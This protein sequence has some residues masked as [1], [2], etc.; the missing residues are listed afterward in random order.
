MTMSQAFEQGMTQ[1]QLMEEICKKLDQVLEQQK[2]RD[3][4]LEEFIKEQRQRDERQ[5]GQL[6][7]IMDRL[8]AGDE[9]F[10]KLEAVVRYA[11]NNAGLAVNYLRVIAKRLQADEE[12]KRVIREDL[13]TMP[14]PPPTP[15]SDRPA[16]IPH[17]GPM[18]GEE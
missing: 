9:L 12:I 13:D 15:P 14:A 11:S 7:K 10:I 4:K 3:E 18:G 16:P 5:D 17:T 2:N 1:E 6:E 8:S